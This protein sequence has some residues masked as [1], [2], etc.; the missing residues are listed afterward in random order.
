MMPNNAS[1]LKLILD[2]CSKNPVIAVGGALVG[3]AAFGFFAHRYGDTVVNSVLKRGGRVS[4]RKDGVGFDTTP[5]A[6]GF[7]ADSEQGKLTVKGVVE[8]LPMEGHS[9][10]DQGKKNKSVIEET[11]RLTIGGKR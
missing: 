9:A 2:F 4:I 8:V 3:L 7:G 6:S 10:V 5:T 11:G 1:N